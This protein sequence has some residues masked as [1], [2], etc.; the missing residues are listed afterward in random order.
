MTLIIILVSIGFALL[1]GIIG[2][3]I[4]CNV[5]TKVESEENKKNYDVFLRCKKLYITNKY[6]TLKDYD[7]IDISEYI[8]KGVI[9]AICGRTRPAEPGEP[10]DRTILYENAALYK[11]KGENEW[12]Y[13]E[14]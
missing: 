3:G 10:Q 7:I 5:G 9:T 11:F 2:F 6:E 14:L 13:L 12:K 1:G 8:K 4:G